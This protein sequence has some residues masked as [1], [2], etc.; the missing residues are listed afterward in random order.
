MTV[1]RATAGPTDAEMAAIL[2]AHEAL[3][4]TPVRAALTAAPA[5]RWRFSGRW[6]IAPT[7]RHRPRQTLKR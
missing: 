4:P 1:V 6:W 5:P 2:A 7:P 3:W